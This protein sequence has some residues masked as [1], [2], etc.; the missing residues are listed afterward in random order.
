MLTIRKLGVRLRPM[1]RKEIFVGLFVIL[2]I[3]G[4]IFGVKKA[5]DAKVKPLVIPTPVETQ[6]LENKFNVTIPS[7]VEK[8]NLQ[9]AFGFEGMGIA[10]RKFANGT[11]SHI[12]IADLPQPASGSY[13]AWLIKDD[14]TKISTG[15]LRLAKGG[16]L[17][18]FTSNTDYSNF[19]K[20]EVKLGERIV[21]SGS[22]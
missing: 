14:T 13:K 8:I 1:G 21:L 11:F 4:I 19:K 17:L 15:V 10:T 22:F 7:D 20:V 12:V 18:E 3:I 5:K 2:V 9:A 6:Q 16:Y